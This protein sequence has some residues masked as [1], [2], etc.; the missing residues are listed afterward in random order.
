MIIA[1]EFLDELMIGLHSAYLLFER[2]WSYAAF[3]HNDVKL[4][5]CSLK[6]AAALRV[7]SP[8]A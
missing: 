8:D 5:S 2:E 1:Q 6:M 3:P 4:N 7:S